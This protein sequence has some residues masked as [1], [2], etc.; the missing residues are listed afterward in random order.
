D[1]APILE[2]ISGEII[3]GALNAAVAAITQQY[4]DAGYLTSRAVLP[5]QPLDG[6]LEIQ[7]IEGTITDIQITGLNRLRPRYITSRVRQGIGTPLNINTLEDQLRLFN[8][9]ANIDRFN[10]A[11]LQDQELGT[12]ILQL[13]ITEADP[14]FGTA[15]IDNYSAAAVGST[16]TGLG[17]GYRNLLG[18][19]D[20]AGISYILTPAGGSH[21]WDFNYAVP[22]NPMNGTI[23]ARFVNDRNKII[24]RPF[25]ALGIR[26]A[27]QL[28]EISFRQPLIR[29][30]REEFALSLGFTHKLGQ[31]FLFQNVAQ[32]FSLGA[33]ADGKTRTSV[34]RFG[35]DY[36]RRDR[37]G[38]WSG[39]SQFNIGTGLFNAT[40]NANPIPDGQFLSWLGQ[41]RR[42]EVINPKHQI[43]I[44]GDLQ[45]TGDNLLS[46]ETFG[47]GGGQTLRGYRQGA[48]SGD[49]GFRFVVEN[50]IALVQNEQGAK[51]LQIAPF[52]DVGKVWNNG[53]NPRQIPDNR[54]LVGLGTGFIWQ[55]IEKLNVRLDFTLPVVN[56]RDRQTDLQD[57]GIYFSLSY[58]F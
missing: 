2:T 33:G 35:K 34:L 20:V 49:N 14:F 53:S 43:L 5:A 50:R 38:A 31:T 22:L 56:L 18:M 23:Q 10:T 19:G 15:F 36:I 7:V 6:N 4:I 28:Y 40:N 30:P 42:I 46:S 27:S 1:L 55:P 44:E 26:G 11:L 24:K 58:G 47:I 45:L 13:E 37:T 12:S 52:V 8:L 48:R 41:V 29:N 21:I 3:L 25:D 17:L 9:D 57:D 54:F 32:P 39:R 51:L 16:R